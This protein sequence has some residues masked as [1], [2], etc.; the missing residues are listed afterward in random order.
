MPEGV[1]VTEGCCNA[2]VKSNIK[3]ISLSTGKPYVMSA[4][5]HEPVYVLLLQM[6]YAIILIIM[7]MGMGMITKK[8]H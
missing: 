8:Y 6:L 7:I 4:S 3:L 1:K 5:L 2:F